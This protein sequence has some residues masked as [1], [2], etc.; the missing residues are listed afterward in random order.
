[1]FDF[2]E[3][4]VS[5]QELG[6]RTTITTRDGK[7]VVELY[8]QENKLPIGFA[9]DETLEKTF[10]RFIRNLATSKQTLNSLLAT[11]KLSVL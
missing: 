11:D 6:I 3:M 1:M 5:L 9:K 8:D 10:S 7:Y 4:L 2:E